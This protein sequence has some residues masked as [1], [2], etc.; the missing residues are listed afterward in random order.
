M[1]K[2]KYIIGSPSPL[3]INVHSLNTM[4]ILEHVDV[5]PSE[6]E[7]QGS[8]LTAMRWVISLE[9]SVWNRYWDKCFSR[10]DQFKPHSHLMTQ[11][12]FLL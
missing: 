6:A 2:V 7:N 11:V 12:L 10:R 5:N 3:Y 8:W 1:T 4:K 9:G